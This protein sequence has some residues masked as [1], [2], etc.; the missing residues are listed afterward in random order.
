MFTGIIPA[1]FS[2][3]DENLNVKEDSVK[4][5]MEYCI[6]N[7]ASGF[8]VCGNT[9]EC[10]VLP[11]KTRKQMA[12]AAVKFNRGRVK[13]IVHIGAAHM[14]E[15]YELIDHCNTLDIDAISSLPP[16]FGGYYNMAETINYYRLIAKRSKH[17][18]IAYVWGETG[19]NALELAKGISEIDN[20]VGL[21]LTITDYRAFIEIKQ[22]NN[23]KINVL[24]GPDETLLCGLAAGA[25]GAIG[26]SYNLMP[27]LAVSVY[28][29]FKEGKMN[30]ALEAQRKLTAVI[31]T[32]LNNGTIAHWKQ[33]LSFI[34]FDMGYTVEP[35][36]LPTEEEMKKLKESL[37]KVGYF[38]II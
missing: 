3:Y 38:D 28:N 24:N 11:V 13:L 17:P 19:K 12:E 23:G 30:E 26:T 15:V 34:G 36:L 32:L 31:I 4:E 21:K 37:A 35:R 22:L 6:S 1:L 33:A 16:S 9:G 14:D 10:R 8:Y 25:D 7:G 20:V 27:K 29:L 2:I 5:L 18:V